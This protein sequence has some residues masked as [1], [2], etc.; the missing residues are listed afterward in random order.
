MAGGFVVSAGKAEHTE[1]KNDGGIHVII[2]A[3]CLGMVRTYVRVY[4]YIGVF[5]L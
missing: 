3:C 2:N 1:P 5:K 4:M